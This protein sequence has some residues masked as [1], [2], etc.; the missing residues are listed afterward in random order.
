MI[1]KFIRKPNQKNFLHRTPE[2]LD[3]QNRDDI[4]FYLK[5]E[6]NDYD[7]IGVV[8]VKVPASPQ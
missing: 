2:M 5:G 3:H 4:G 1:T 7:K 8:E 6:V